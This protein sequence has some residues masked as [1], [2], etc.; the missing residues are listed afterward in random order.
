MERKIIIS[1]I[2]LL[3]SFGTAAWALTFSTYSDADT[4]MH[5]STARGG[6]NYMD[7]RGGTIDYA[8]YLRFDLSI[9]DRIIIQDALLTLTISGG[10]SRNDGLSHYRI[11]LYGLNNITGN[12]PQ[13]WDESTLSETGTNPAGAEWTGSIPPD[14]ARVTDLD[15]DTVAGIGEIYG[16]G[17]RG[18]TITV[19]GD[20]LVAFIQS[21]MNDGGLVNFIIGNPDFADRG[22]GLATKEN[23]NAAWRPILEIDY[24]PIPE[25]ASVFLLS[26][27]LFLLR[28]KK[29]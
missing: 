29:S 4:Y 28:K 18:D 26:A 3:I 24:T 17:V 21:R 5:D 6:Y 14:L 27:G 11:A 15:M 1:V 12:T 20:P 25:P 13:N 19:T 9:L 8:G 16:I 22:Y 23:A 7:I 10:A 2:V